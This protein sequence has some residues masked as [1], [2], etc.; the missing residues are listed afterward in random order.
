[1]DKAA[2]QALLDREVEAWSRKPFAALMEE[3]D[4]VVAYQRGD[5][6]GFHQFEVQMLERE[7][8]YLHVLVSIDDGSFRRS[9]SP[10][11][12]GFIVHRD[13]RIEI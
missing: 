10:L 13:G 12:R 8:D 4:D 5:G 1:M 3:L 7:P 2:L 11:S 6:S 9:L